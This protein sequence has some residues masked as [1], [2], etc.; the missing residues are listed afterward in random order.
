MLGNYRKCHKEPGKGRNLQISWI[1]WNSLASP[2]MGW[3]LFVCLLLS[4]M[5]SLSVLYSIEQ[6][7]HS[8]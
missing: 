3:S 6:F 5:V 2:M 7:K 1:K 8:P 4:V